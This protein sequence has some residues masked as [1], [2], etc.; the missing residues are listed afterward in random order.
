MNCHKKNGKEKKAIIPH[1]NN[2]DFEKMFS[3]RLTPA[4]FNKTYKK[5]EK[6]K[7]AATAPCST[8]NFIYSLKEKLLSSA[9]IRHL[10]VGY[11]LKNDA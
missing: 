5:K 6:K 3:K 10:C 4:C 2:I 7:T 1:P 9:S 8:T 11:L